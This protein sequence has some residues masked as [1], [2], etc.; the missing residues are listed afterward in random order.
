MAEGQYTPVAGQPGSPVQGGERTVGNVYAQQGGQAFGFSTEKTPEDDCFCCGE[1]KAGLCCTFPIYFCSADRSYMAEQ[2]MMKYS[3]CTCTQQV[4]VE[5]ANI[6]GTNARFHFTRALCPC[7]DSTM[8]IT[9]GQRTVGTVVSH[10]R[11]PWE[12]C[13]EFTAVEAIDAG[14]QPK[15]ARREPCCYDGRIFW[16]YSCC[17]YQELL[18]PITGYQN[19]NQTLGWM[20]YRYHCCFPHYPQWVGYKNW[21][22]GTGSTDDQ[23][24]LL[25]IGLMRWINLTT[26]KKQNN[27]GN[28]EGFGGGGMATTGM[29]S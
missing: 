1:Y 29:M 11:M 28:A 25:G 10:P 5:N 22:Q 7:S 20:S 24:L 13:G 17:G 19:A 2:S 15:F 23:L 26:Q 16:Q 27:Q 4:T 3:I 14:Q 21:P 18:W 8:V 12:I 9:E 6:L